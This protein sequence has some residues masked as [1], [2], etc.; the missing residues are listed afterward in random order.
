LL[1]R[2]PDPEFERLLHGEKPT[3]RKMTEAVA[4]AAAY[5]RV[6]PRTVRELL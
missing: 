1:A 3:E 5:L 2:I 4:E 6:C